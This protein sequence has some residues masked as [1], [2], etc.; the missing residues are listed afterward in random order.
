MSASVHPR[1]IGPNQPAP[2]RRMWGL[3]PR[4][5]AILAGILIATALI[6]MPSLRYGWVW[7]DKAEIVERSALQSWAG[8]AKSF[9]YDSWWF[10]DPD[11]L[12]QSAYYR[13][14][15][16]VWLALNYMILGVHPAAWHLEKIVLELIGVILCFR[17][18]QLLT[19][20][21]AIALLAAAIFGLIPANV[22][23]V[24]W[25]SAIPEPLS[26]I[27]EMGAMICFIQR[28]PGT[29]SSR[30]LVFALILYAGALLTHE[31]AVLFW[32][33]VAAYL[34]L[35]EGLRP[36]EAIRRA[37]PFALLAVA[38]SVA[39]WHV[40]GAAFFGMPDFDPPSIVLGWA[41]P[42]PRYGPLDIML[43]APV[44]MLTYFGALIVPGIAGPTHDVNWVTRASAIAFVEAGALVALALIA[45]ALIR[46]S[47]DR[48]LYLFCVVWSLIAIAPAMNLKALAFLVED[49]ILYAPSVAWSI[50]LAVVAV[51][52][53][54]GSARARMAVAGAMALLLAAYAISAVRVERYWHDDLTLFR[55]LVAIAPHQPEYIRELVDQLNDK[56]DPTGA[57]NALQDA[58]NRD[59][60]NLYLHMKLADQYAMM[61]RGSD[62]IAETKKIKA[63]R[64]RAG[65]ANRARSR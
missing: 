29:G 23:S 52:I 61:R 24:V 6:Y 39:R 42:R 8:I 46:R 45:M 10:R 30:G 19:K 64:A 36:G 40:L 59:A 20:N 21:T 48:N 4:E 62:F 14:L 49:R 35:I 12:P 1:A 31:T 27:F 63:L 56:G 9:I 28:K 13:P 43:T 7:D 38:Y 26:A 53:A 57:M 58:V 33:V 34:F 51:R 25:N 16:L 55:G 5:Q 54:S 18:A 17:L 41:A 11:H 65:A 22:E 37:A 60:D 47:R 50:A 15:Q 32:I 3:E 44:V 2:V